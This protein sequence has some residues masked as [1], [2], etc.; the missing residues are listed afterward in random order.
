[1]NT[2]DLFWTLL[3]AATGMVVLLGGSF[4]VQAAWRR[5]FPEYPVD[6]DVLAERLGCQQCPRQS[7]CEHRTDRMLAGSP[8]SHSPSLQ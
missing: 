7:Q 5:V 6:Q 1:M 2:L 4:L 3:K 8:D